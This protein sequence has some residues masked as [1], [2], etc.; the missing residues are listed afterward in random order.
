[1]PEVTEIERLQKEISR[2]QHSVDFY[3]RR[4][5]AMQRWQSC[6]RDPER[7]IV[8]DILANG[9]TLPATHAGDRYGACQIP[10][11][12]STTLQ[13]AL[14]QL[15]KQL[16]PLEPE[17]AAVLHEHLEDLYLEGGGTPT[18]QT[19]EEL[20]EHIKKGRDVPF[21]AGAFLDRF[22]PPEKS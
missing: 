18:I 8:C 6:M 13:E 15:A 2:L 22:D 14:L 11:E 12:A 4:C 19:T 17:F 10:E 7:T 16:K 9:E 1:M 20:A 21:N 3:K 5:D